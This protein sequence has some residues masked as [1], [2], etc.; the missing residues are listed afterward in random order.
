MKYGAF[1][2]IFLNQLTE[3]LV[4][5]MLRRVSCNSTIGTMMINHDK[6]IGFGGS[7]FESPPFVDPFEAGQMALGVKD[8]G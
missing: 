7:N 3:N 8:L 4:C 1:L 6:P 2:E 5:H